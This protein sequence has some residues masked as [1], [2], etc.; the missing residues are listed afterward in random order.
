LKRADAELYWPSQQ[1]IAYAFGTT[2]TTVKAWI[3][4]GAPRRQAQGYPVSEWCRWFAWRERERATIGESLTEARRRKTAAEADL[5][6][7]RR[8]KAREEVISV[9]Q[10]KTRCE[11]IVRTF[12]GILDRQPTEMGAAVATGLHGVRLDEVSKIIEGW[13]NATRCALVRTD[14]DNEQAK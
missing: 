1:A 2:I 8:Q 6:E 5:V 3:N 13:N 4:S 7:I 14:E 12:I 9:D 10:H 11:R